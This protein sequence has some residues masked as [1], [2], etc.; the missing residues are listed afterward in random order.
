MS[1]TLQ[2][3]PWPENTDVNEKKKKK[4]FEAG[5][6]IEKKCTFLASCEIHS[7]LKLCCIAQRHYIAHFLHS[8]QCELM[9]QKE[10]QQVDKQKHTSADCSSIIDYCH[11]TGKS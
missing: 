6:N 9:L 4:I 7:L 5:S 10:K 2:R 3:A 8:A 11:S 1:S